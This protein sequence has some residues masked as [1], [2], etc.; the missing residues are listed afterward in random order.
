MKRRTTVLLNLLLVLALGISW[1]S[2]GCGKKDDAAVGQ[3]KPAPAEE[4][5][6][7]KPVNVA[8]KMAETETV[9]EAFTL[10]GTLE[11]WEDITLSLEQPG[12]IKWIG[13]KE[14]DRVRAG[15][16]ILRIDKESLLASHARNQTD[17]D[18]K[19]KQLERAET[20]LDKQLISERDRDEALRA[21]ES[22]RADLSQTAIALDKS[23]LVS[24]IDG[25]L[26]SLLVDRGEYGNA[27][28][29]AA[30]VVQVQRLKVLVDVPEK[31]V[32]SLKVGQEVMV[33]PA[34]VNVEGVGRKGRIIHVSYQADQMTRTYLAKV[35]IDNR[36]GFLR[37]GMIVRVRFVKR[38]LEDVLTAPLYAVLDRDGLKYVFVEENGTA[39]LREVHLGP[40]INGKVV[41]F[42][43]IQE[44]EQLVI[45]GQQLIADGGR[46]KVIEE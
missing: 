17:F 35:E 15:D 39:V 34:E 1:G 23:S 13:P 5:K 22:A 37:P 30:V 26:D 41:V 46:V 18:I 36:D 44:G 14:G 10:P 20:L 6:A 33:L 11:A 29:P 2:V 31:D 3:E 24:P 25:I 4:V 12:P 8:V 28:A 7:V 42:G 19:K 32:A 16:E 9:A 27:G 38:I 43:G 40:V 45:K 21:Y